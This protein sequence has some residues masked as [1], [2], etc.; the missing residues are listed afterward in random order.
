MRAAME[1]LNRIHEVEEDRPWPARF[2]R[3]VLIAVAVGGLIVLAAALLLVAACSS[4]TG[5][6]AATSRCAAC[7]S[8]RG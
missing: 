5:P 2:V 1:A 6:T 7:R 4:T 8:A 3:S